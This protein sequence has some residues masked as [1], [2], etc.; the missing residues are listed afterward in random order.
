VTIFKI[1]FET[2]IS[3]IVGSAGWS[4][5][6]K[7]SIIVYCPPLSKVW[8]QLQSS[9]KLIL[10]SQNTRHFCYHLQTQHDWCSVVMF[11]QAYFWQISLFSEAITEYCTQRRCL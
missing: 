11:V 6:S 10:G 2:A 1:D 7:T 5:I 3:S 8:L 9:T 4:C